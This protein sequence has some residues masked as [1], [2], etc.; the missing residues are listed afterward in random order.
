MEKFKNKYRIPSSRAD[1]WNYSSSGFYFITICTYNKENLF[2]KIRDGVVELSQLGLIVKLEWEKSFLIRNELF[3]D[4]YVIMPNHI[5]AVVEI[6]KNPSDNDKINNFIVETHGRASLPRRTPK[7]ISSFI[8]GFKSS[9]TRRINTFRNKPKERVWQSR[10]YDH[11]IL[12]ER[13][14]LNIKN[15]I[16]DNPSNWEMDKLCVD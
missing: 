7:S 12:N 3:C 14:Y 4:E 1:W 13:E 5:H 6:R 10:F 16:L 15:Y 9:A 11:I 2:G 8:A